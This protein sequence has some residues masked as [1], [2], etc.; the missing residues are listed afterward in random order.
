MLSIRAQPDW[1]YEFPDQTEPD[2][3]ICWTGTAGPD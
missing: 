1:A 3:Q 2:S